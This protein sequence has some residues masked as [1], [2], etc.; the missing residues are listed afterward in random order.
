M[1]NF[2]GDFM[3]NLFAALKN[4]QTP[5][6]QGADIQN[7]NV[8]ISKN[9]L[10]ALEILG[11]LGT[12]DTITG[13]VSKI[14]GNSATIIINGNVNIE[15]NLDADIPLKE[16]N[17][18]LF[19]VEK[20][21]GNSVTLRPL[22]TNVSNLN[23]ADAAL[24]E[25]EI[26]MN[27]KSYTMLSSMI[28]KGLPIDKESVTSL[29][30]SVVQNPEVPVNEIVTMKSIGLPVTNDNIMRFD[31]IVNFESKISD[32]ISYVID[33]IPKELENLIESDYDSFM[34]LS[35]SI[36]SDDLKKAENLSS[37]E[38]PLIENAV[39]NE[40]E[41]AGNESGIIDNKMTLENVLD[42]EVL[43]SEGG[44]ITENKAFNKEDIIEVGNEQKL[45]A[46]FFK[47]DSK[48]IKD[49]AEVLNLAKN[50]LSDENVS[51]EDKEIVVK[52]DVF[53]NAL[54]DKLSKEWLIEPSDFK[55]SKSVNEHFEKILKVCEN[56]T[57]TMGNELRN[58]E[59]LTNT[60]N[61]FR[62]NLNFLDNLN[63]FAPYIQIPMRMGEEAN[64][65]DLYV[66]AKKKNL[67]ENSDNLTALLRLDMK[68][69]GPMEVYVRLNSG[70]NLTTDFTF[71]SEESLIFI[72]KNIDVLNNRLEKIGYNIKNSF[73]TKKTAPP[74]F[75]DDKP[76]KDSDVINLY[77][78]DVRA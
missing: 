27:E 64:T 47:N 14:Q 78:F 36:L 15:A 74:I 17:P 57:E 53:K 66:Y 62:E 26:P 61:N 69:L 73:N 51:K 12:N 13:I 59:T 35:E 20:D 60:V 54:K 46:L 77:K 4:I 6:V 37:N 7:V 50:I 39:N 33:E 44:E 49:N 38:N 65:G 43:K 23:L 30:R 68:N 3:D 48:D 40:I 32:S 19:E 29:Y 67:L 75:K 5:S 18:V 45:S 34:K 10:M 24:K 25:A 16:G 70:K 31:S 42:K 63:N 56:I 72:E 41:T 21:K 11:N 9:D 71:E 58:S 1:I 52:S 55:N 2:Y 22:F 8:G 28:E 76:K